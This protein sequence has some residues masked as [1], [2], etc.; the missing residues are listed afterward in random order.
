MGQNNKKGFSVIELV[1]AIGIIAII[2]AVTLPNLF[3]RK[4]TTELNNTVNQISVTLREAQ[5]RAISQSGDTEWGV[6]FEN[7][8]PSYN[9]SSSSYFAMFS[10]PNYTPSTRVNYTPLPQGVDYVTST[11]AIGSSTSVVFSQITGRSDKPLFYLGLSLTRDPQITLD[12][13]VLQSGQVTVLTKEILVASLY[14]SLQDILQLAKTAQQN[15]KDRVNGELWGVR[16]QNPTGAVP[17]A[18]LFYGNYTVTK[19]LDLLP[20]ISYNP[21]IIPKGSSLDITFSSSGKPSQEVTVTTYLI[22][23]PAVSTYVQIDKNGICAQGSCGNPP[24]TTPPTVAVS[25]PPNGNTVTG[26]MLVSADASDNIGVVGVQ[27][28]LDGANLGVEDISSPFFIYW[29]TTLTANGSHVLTAT[30]RDAA[31]NTSTSAGITVNV[32]NGGGGCFTY[33]TLVDTPSGPR[34]IGT[35]GVGDTV[36]AYDETTSKTVESQVSQVFV[37]TG[38]SYGIVTFN[39]GTSLEVTSVHPFYNPS[40]KQWLSIGEMQPGDSVLRGIGHA[41]H[42]VTIRSKEFTSGRGT[43]Y[44]IE[45]N[46]YHTYYV[47]GILV[48]NKLKK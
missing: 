17:Y 48:H 4:S 44:N 39:D 36:Y 12:I 40:S 14:G 41:A 22:S 16:F 46:R 1:L 3:G 34:A 7:V 30:A 24:D 11:L 20:G 31:G 2:A 19:R 42:P 43:V 26:N 28:K 32:V 8:D 10:S 21:T 37:H 27:F 13:S 23:Y 5:S 25:S 33:G 9:N 45:V 29:N 15:S 18:E 47:N 6:R 35:L 38:K